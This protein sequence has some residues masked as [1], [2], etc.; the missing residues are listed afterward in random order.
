MVIDGIVFAVILAFL[1]GGSFKGFNEIQ[2]RG[3][4]VIVGLCI[5]QLIL[6]LIS[7]YIDWLGNALPYWVNL[8]S[9]IFLI[10]TLLNWRISGFLL[11]SLGILL[12]IAV[13]VANGGKMPVSLEAANMV[14]PEY[15]EQLYQD[16]IKHMVM[17]EGNYLWFLGDIIPLPS[18]YPLKKV[19]SI[20][21]VLI[22][23]GG[24]IFIWK[25][26]F[27][28]KREKNEKLGGEIL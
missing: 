7:P 8:F 5:V 16:G 12:N 9:F 6:L 27:L 1:R 10:L 23:V 17:N 25:T 26:M 2:F 4:K 18:P 28:I 14:Y 15:I 22:N 19:I 3:G 21:D 13:M 20:G 11:V 24:F